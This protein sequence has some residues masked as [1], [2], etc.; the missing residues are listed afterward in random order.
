MK[1]KLILDQQIEYRL[2]ITINITSTVLTVRFP[3]REVWVMEMMIISMTMVVAMMMLA[4]N[5]SGGLG[6]G[7][8]SEPPID[9]GGRAGANNLMMIIIMIMIIVIVIIM[10]TQYIPTSW[11]Y[12]MFYASPSGNMSCSM[13]H[14]PTTH[15]D[16]YHQRH[17]HQLVVVVGLVCHQPVHQH[18]HHR[19]HFY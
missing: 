8:P 10:V 18:C 7:F 11:E 17:H 6:K 1:Q 3:E 15:I 16:Y 12:V 9:G 14:N 13:C 19:D 2:K 4:I 5:L